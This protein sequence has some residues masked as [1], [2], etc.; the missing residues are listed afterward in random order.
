ME[1]CECGGWMIYVG[2][3]EINNRTLVL[4]R[5]IKCSTGKFIVKEAKDGS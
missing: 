2:E 1:K 5:C 3:Y 4:L